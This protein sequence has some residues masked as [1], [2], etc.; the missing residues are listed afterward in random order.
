MSRLVLLRFRAVSIVPLPG[1]PPAHVPLYTRLFQHFLFGFLE[2]P[3]I[4]A[5]QVFIATPAILQIF[6]VSMRAQ[7]EPTGLALAVDHGT[8]VLAGALLAEEAAHVHVVLAFGRLSGAFGVS[9]ITE[10]KDLMTQGFVLASLQLL[11]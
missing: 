6:L 8:P 7:A 11:S 5:F 3:Y 4:F 10:G 2:I 1:L 9:F